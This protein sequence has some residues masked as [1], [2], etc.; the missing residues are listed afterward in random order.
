MKK[1]QQLRLVFLLLF[2]AILGGT[3]GAQPAHADTVSEF[4]GT[5]FTQEVPP[6]AYDESYNE[7]IGPILFD[8]FGNGLEPFFFTDPVTSGTLRTCTSDSCSES[9]SGT[10]VGGTISM[11]LDDPAPPALVATITG[12]SYSGYN[13]VPCFYPYCNA[14][15]GQ[16]IN[17]TGVW[18][19]GW[20]TVGTLSAGFD[21]SV[22]GNPNAA[23]LTMTTTTAPTTVPEPGSMTLLGTGM[24]LLV[25]SLRRRL[26]NSSLVP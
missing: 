20:T 4:T 13:Q 12:G 5:W 15:D 11:Y 22:A 16:T 3:W 2:V 6:S 25:T 19:N 9:Y 18:A 7:S 24:L 14:Y 17:F 10:F 21:D 1:L 26:Q 8:Q 23:T